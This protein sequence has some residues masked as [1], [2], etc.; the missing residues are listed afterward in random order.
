MSGLS[1]RTYSCGGEGSRFG[2]G[3]DSGAFGAADGAGAFEKNLRIPFFLVNLRSV[4]M[5]EGTSD[6]SDDSSELI[7]AVVVF[8][9]GE[10]FGWSR[11]R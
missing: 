5:S 10:L 6:S 7:L 4:S 2:R 3:G 11:E 1:A 9:G 8:E